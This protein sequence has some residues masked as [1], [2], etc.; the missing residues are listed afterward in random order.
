MEALG[1]F[2]VEAVVPVYIGPCPKAVEG[3]GEE[4]ERAKI[5]RGTGVAFGTLPPSA[6][7]HP[8][9]PQTLPSHWRKYVFL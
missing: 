4:G 9:Q 5:E 8:K 7:S 1:S 6:S 2:L 3:T